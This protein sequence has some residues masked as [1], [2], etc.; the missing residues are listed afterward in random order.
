MT[1]LDP[2][3]ADGG[4]HDHGIVRPDTVRSNPGAPLME[5]ARRGPIVFLWPRMCFTNHRLHCGGSQSTSSA[6]RPCFWSAMQLRHCECQLAA[7]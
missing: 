3:G 1:T 7:R 5:E 4:R 2:D 6:S